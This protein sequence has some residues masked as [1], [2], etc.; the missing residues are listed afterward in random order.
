MTTKNILMVGLGISLFIFSLLCIPFIP[1]MG[2]GA[3]I[4]WVTVILNVPY[5][6]ESNEV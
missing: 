5:V 3:A 1:S 4:G 6:G 2:F